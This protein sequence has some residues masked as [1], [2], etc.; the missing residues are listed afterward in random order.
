[1]NGVIRVGSA[2]LCVV[3]GSARVITVVPRHA[4]FLLLHK[5]IAPCRGIHT[6]HTLIHITVHLVSAAGNVLVHDLFV[7]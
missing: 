4:V 3:S 1:M 7:V 5:R 2:V 6:V